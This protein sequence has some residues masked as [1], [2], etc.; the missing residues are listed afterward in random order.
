MELREFFN[1]MQTGEADPSEEDKI[2]KK[3]DEAQAKYEADVGV[4]VPE[5][6]GV[7]YPAEFDIAER[8]VTMGPLRGAMS[9]AQSMT[10]KPIVEKLKES[11][12]AP[13]T[14][15]AGKTV[16]TTEINRALRNASPRTQDTI[17]NTPGMMDRVRKEGIQVIKDMEDKLVSKTRSV[18]RAMMGAKT[19]E[20][21]QTGSEL[22]VQKKFRQE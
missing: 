2:K 14:A 5:E 16:S 11:M 20:Q 12:P 21:R 7:E 4:K 10:K 8:A 1:K 19:P 9:A 3:A 15:P 17:L 18:G 13:A 6:A 22:L